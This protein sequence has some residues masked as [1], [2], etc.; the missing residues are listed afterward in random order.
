MKI[1]TALL[2]L[3]AAISLLSNHHAAAQNCK[4]GIRCGNSC[5]PANRTCRINSSP[6]TTK[7]QFR[8]P[9]TTHLNPTSSLPHT[10]KQTSQAQDKWVGSIAD[11]IYFLAT[12]SAA[13]DLAPS[14]KQMFASEIDAIRLGFKRSSVPECQ[15]P[16]P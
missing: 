5:I 8:T 16:A 10:S 4:K 7:S 14:N 1:K 13:K 2:A 15:S 12:C 11:K 3:I 9:S 6:L